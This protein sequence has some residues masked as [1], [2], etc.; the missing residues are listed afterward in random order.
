ML[1]SQITPE[2][3]GQEGMSAQSKEILMHADMINLQKVAQNF[4]YRISTFI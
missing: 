2:S 3:C 1:I 4:N